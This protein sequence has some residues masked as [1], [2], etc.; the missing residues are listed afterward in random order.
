[1]TL[2]L[3]IVDAPPRRVG[4]YRL[5]QRIG[6]GAMGAVYTAVDERT[7]RRVA[8]K[9]MMADLEDDRAT[10]ERFLRE[11][12]ITAELQHPNI[13]RLL[14]FGEE[15]GRPFMAME[16][17][18]GQPLPAYLSTPRTLDAR[19][20][21]LQ[22]VVEGLRIAPARGIVHRDIKPSNVFVQ[23]NGEDRTVKLLDFG[24]ARV[25]LSQLT[26]GGAVVGTPEYMSPEQASGTPLDARSDLFS[27][28]AVAYFVLSGR[29][30]FAAANLP[31]VIDSVKHRDPVPLTDAEAPAAIR[32]IVARA[33]AKSPADR[34]P[35]AEAMLA[36][37]AAAR[38]Q[39][40]SLLARAS[41]W[42]RQLSGAAGQSTTEWLMIAGVL[43]AVAAFLVETVPSA[44][45]TFM[46]AMATSV[47]TIAP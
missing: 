2:A 29:A 11:A 30:P 16:L 14:D 12:R 22:Q 46:K 28:G 43:T 40:R 9:L 5:E 39:R 26:A 10:R 27:A 47:R 4:V 13:V 24:I 45:G 7:G 38:G 21:L 33:L 37:L 15:Q 18:H 41:S 31:Q 17:L 8:I 42:W 35:T 23:E 25:P 36:D 32:R 44:L 19:L 3:G 6:R 34:Y 1:M 20:D